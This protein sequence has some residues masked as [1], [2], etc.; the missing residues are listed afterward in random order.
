MCF[1]HTILEVFGVKIQNPLYHFSSGSASFNYTAV[2]SYDLV[3]YLQCPCGGNTHTYECNLQVCGGN[4]HTYECNLQIWSLRSLIPG[5]Y[6]FFSVLY[7][8]HIKLFT[9]LKAYQTHNILSVQVSYKRRYPSGLLVCQTGL[10]CHQ[11]PRWG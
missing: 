7:L 10:I 6:R 8:Y 4:T 9:I 11:R 2:M 1:N 5:L 3:L